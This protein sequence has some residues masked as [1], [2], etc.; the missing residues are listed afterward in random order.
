MSEEGETRSATAPLTT[1]SWLG[2]GDTLTGTSFLA[3]V[4]YNFFTTIIDGITYGIDESGFTL[5]QSF[6]SNY[7]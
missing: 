6:A 4:F 3:I 2:H 1:P 5:T 7:R